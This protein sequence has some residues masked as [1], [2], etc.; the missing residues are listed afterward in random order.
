MSGTFR[1][2]ALPLELREQIYSLYFH[3]PDRL[4]T[5]EDSGGR[6]QFDFDLLRVCKQVYAEAQTVFRRENIFV[7]VETPWPNAGALQ[8]APKKVCMLCGC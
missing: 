8:P 4:H 7:K 3:P 1:F 2:L 6:Y 5:L